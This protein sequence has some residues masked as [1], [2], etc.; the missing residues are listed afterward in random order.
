MNEPSKDAYDAEYLVLHEFAK[1][2]KEKLSVESWDYIMGGAETE[3]TFK[4]NRQ[5]LDSVA[6]RPRVLCD[7]DDIDASGTLLGC[8]MRIPVLLAPIGSL[9]DFIPGGGAG[10]TLAAERFGNMHMLS[11]TCHPGLEEVAAAAPD[12]QKIFQLYVRGDRAWVDD[13]IRRAIDVGYVGFCFTVDLDAYGRRERDLAKRHKTTSR[14][15]AKGENFQ[16]RFSWDDIKRIRDEF[17]IPLILKGIATAEDAAMAVEHGINVVYVSNHGGRQ[18]DHGRG[19]LEVLP[20]IVSAVSGKAEIIFDGGVMRGNDVVKAM[21]MGVNAV[22]I[23]RLQAL[24][25]AAAGVEGMVRMLEILELEIITTL[26]LLGVRNYDELL[27]GNYLHACDPIREAG[28]LSAFPLLD[29]G[30]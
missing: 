19:G 12:Y 14:Q 29:E 26:R 25:G 8:P 23:G 18:L 16:Y 9:Q 21:A 1:A 2:A 30:Y 22:G 6:F 28:A 24:A 7:V 17:D 5:A 11:S 3:T 20:E 15:K 4:R 10:P 27:K 13:H